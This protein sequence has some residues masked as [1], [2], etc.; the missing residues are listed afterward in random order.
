MRRGLHEA[1]G[2][3]ACRSK[4]SYASKRLAALH[5]NE[6][7]ARIVPRVEERSHC[8]DRRL[9]ERAAEV[10]REVKPFEWRFVATP[11]DENRN[12]RQEPEN[13]SEEHAHG[14]AGRKVLHPT[15]LHLAAA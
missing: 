14:C 6:I 15:D 9:S 3:V 12:N 8:S 5:K 2:D 13:G 1:H 7:S 4:A 10:L 11:N